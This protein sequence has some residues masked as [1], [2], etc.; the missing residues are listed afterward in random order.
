VHPATLKTFPAGLQQKIAE[1][2]SQGGNIFVSG[3]YV[4][5][6]LWEA[7]EPLDA[8]KQFAT[9]VLKYSLRTGHA[10]VTGKARS[11]AS[12]F[13]VFEGAVE[14]HSKLNPEW[15]AVE[16]PDAI[17]PAGEGAYT[18]FRYSENNLSAGIVYEGPYRTCVLGFPFEVIKEREQRDILMKS[19]LSF[20]S[21]K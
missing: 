10:A 21:E 7:E 17:E 20:F 1:Y 16:S 3:A 2:C 4:G 5:S 15:Y 13:P 19:I 18:Q 11:V 12:P 6:D 8:D 9:D 14:F